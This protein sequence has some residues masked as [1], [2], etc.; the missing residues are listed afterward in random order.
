MRL[1]PF[2]QPFLALPLVVVKQLSL[3]HLPALVRDQGSQ[4]L[5]VEAAV[6]EAQA[7]VHAVG[8]Q[9]QSFLA[10]VVLTRNTHR[11]TLWSDHKCRIKC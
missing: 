8:R 3:T 2:W 6:A 7:A 9:L 4:W 1:S 10:N 11:H 5:R